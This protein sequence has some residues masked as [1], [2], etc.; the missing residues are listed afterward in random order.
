MELIKYLI[1]RVI[2]AVLHIFWLF[3]VNRS[4]VFFVN[5]HSYTFSDNLKYLALYMLDHY[6]E[7]DL[8]FSL[9][10]PD[11]LKGSRIRPVRFLSIQ[12]FY[13]AATCGVFL[14]NNGGTAYLPFRRSQLV[15]NTWH[16]GGPYKVT[17]IDVIDDRWYKKDTKYN[18]DKIDYILSSCRVCAEREFMHGMYYRPEQCIG[19]GSPRLDHIINHK[20]SGAVK[21]RIHQHFG[22]PEDRKILLYA[23]T[24]RGA[25]SDYNGA[26]SDEGLEINRV[27]TIEALKKRFGGEWVFAIRLHPRLKDVQIKDQS[28]INCSFYPDVQ[29]LLAATDVLITD[30]S[31]IMWDFSFTK[32]PVFL[33]ATDLND[34]EVKRG[35]LIPPEKWPYPIA[36]T[37]DEMERNILDYD[38]EQYLTRLQEH[39]EACGSYE[40][41]IACSSIMK[42]IKDYPEKA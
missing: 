17:G 34:Y 38:Q 12:H 35:F 2:S 16:G 13:H 41:G 10:N 18:T 24:F 29:E 39:Y 40:Q 25:F 14:T 20:E 32:R 8:Y 22:I 11:E 5:D 27:R 42:I 26:L 7:Y 21:E 28:I 9:K 19:T 23:P 6:A 37:N 4:K 30:Y 1:K 36:A 31:S 33:F 3:P 15:I